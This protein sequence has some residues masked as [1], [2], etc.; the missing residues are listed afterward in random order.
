VLFIALPPKNGILID[1]EASSA[2]CFAIA[3]THFRPT[4]QPNQDALKRPEFGMKSNPLII[5]KLYT[6]GV[7]N[8]HTAAMLLTAYL[9]S[10]WCKP[11]SNVAGFLFPGGG[12]L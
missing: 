2:E 8:L 7:D 6:F 10:L 12:H 4:M 9:P 5:H 1:A 3:K 11:S